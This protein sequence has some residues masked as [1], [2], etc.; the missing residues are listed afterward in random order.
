M[1]RDKK[2]VRTH[3]QILKK[4]GL[5]TGKGDLDIFSPIDGTKIGSL[6]QHSATDVKKAAEKAD[7]A[8]REWRKVPAPVRGEL[9]RLLGEEL[10]DS[11]E[12]L[13]Q[14]V[15]LECGKI[16]SE[17]R[18]EVQE[19]IDICDYAV[20]LS[21]QLY[22][23]TMVSERPGHHMREL[24]HP[25][26]P[27]G[28]I[29]A[30]NFPVAVWAWNAALALVCGNSLIWKPSEKTP[31]AALACQFF[32]TGPPPNSEKPGTIYQKT[33]PKSLSAVAKWAMRYHAILQS[34]YQRDRQRPHRQGRR[35]SRRFSPW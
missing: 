6:K 28:I 9:V 13:A 22:G 19:M 16:I 31:L 30:F 8:F 14:L 29:T 26:G 12:D 21:R 5:G 32:S 24:W 18:G 1:W 11:K 17:G 4:F 7:K 23:L 20:G 25:L 35:R 27:V 10:R 34:P 3:Q 33:F 2:I 15:T